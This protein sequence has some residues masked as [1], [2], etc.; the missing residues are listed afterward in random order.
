M[1]CDL[2]Y[3]RTVGRPEA[4]VRHGLSV[5]RAVL[6]HARGGRGP[7]PRAAAEPVRVRRRRRCA[8][9]TTL[10]VPSPTDARRRSAP[11]P[12]RAR[13]RAEQ[14][15]EEALCVTA[16]RPLSPSPP[17]RRAARSTAAASS[18]PPAAPRCWPPP[19]SGR[20]A[21]V[22]RARRRRRSTV[23]LDAADAL[24]VGEARA[25]AAAT[26][27]RR[28]WCALDATARR[29]LRPP[30]PAPRLPG[31]VVGRARP[32][33]V[34]VPPRRLR[35]AHRAGAVRPAAPRPHAGD[36]DDRVTVRGSPEEDEDMQRKTTHD[37]GRQPAPPRCR[38]AASCRIRRRVGLLAGRP[39]ARLGRR[40]LRRATRPRRPTCASASSRSPTARRS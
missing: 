17:R 15:L 20:R 36:G 16:R 21:R 14:H 35:R 28:W 32:L 3:D 27:A 24:A 7:A 13:S 29:R 18:A 39:A 10:M 8:R 22:A 25:V 9:A 6:R 4:D 23:A 38:A 30:L 1:K 5:G 19:A 12:R 26:A 33:R 40:R 11:A 34:P 37:N 31:A 2:C